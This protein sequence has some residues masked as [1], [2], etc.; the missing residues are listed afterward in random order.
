LVVVFK[1]FQGQQGDLETTAEKFRRKTSRSKSGG[2]PH[3]LTLARDPM[4]NVMAVVSSAGSV[5][6][7]LQAGLDWL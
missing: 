7:G 1:M 3:A 2:K 5:D 4:R 6:G